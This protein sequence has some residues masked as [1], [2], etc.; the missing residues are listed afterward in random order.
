[1]INIDMAVSIFLVSCIW[2]W[3][4]GALSTMFSCA[5][6]DAPRPENLCWFDLVFL[7]LNVAAFNVVF[8][9]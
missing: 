9:S 8:W 3:A 6:S 4:A 1:M 7:I 5:I 2:A